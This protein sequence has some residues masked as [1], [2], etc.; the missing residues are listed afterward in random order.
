MMAYFEMTEKNRRLFDRARANV[1][2]LCCRA[3]ALSADFS[4]WGA[5]DRNDSEYIEEVEADLKHL[6]NRAEDLKLA[7]DA[8]KEVIHKEEECAADAT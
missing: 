5:N 7:L 3:E 2:Q 1:K 8:M 4:C 6:L